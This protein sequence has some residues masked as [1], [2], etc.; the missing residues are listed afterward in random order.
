MTVKELLFGSSPVLAALKANRRTLHRLF[1]YSSNAES[2]AQSPVV[3][4]NRDAAISLAQKLNVKVVKS[5][6]PAGGASLLN[7]VTHNGLVLECGPLPQLNIKGLSPVSRQ[8]ETCHNS[9]YFASVSDKEH[10]DFDFEASAD[11]GRIKVPLW[12]ALDQVNDPQN[13]GAI[14][15]TCHFFQVDGIVTTSQSTAP[16]SPTVSKASAGSLELYPTLYSTKNLPSFLQDCKD[17]GWLVYGTDVSS[18]TAKVISCWKRPPIESPVILVMG[19]EGEGLRKT[20]S[21]KCDKHL[22]IPN[23]SVA[24]I[25]TLDSDDQSKGILDSL[26]VSVATGILLTSLLRK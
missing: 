8:S 15:R 14:I 18:P 11:P 17:S 13:L 26:N 6:K 21:A 1:V 9:S 10:V 25:G 22:L 23:D 24:E 19:S 4:R 5:A 16:L 2:S 7:N 12:L 3:N 20:V